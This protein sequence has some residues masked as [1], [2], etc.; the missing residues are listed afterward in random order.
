MWNFLTEGVR[1][2][3]KGDVP[4][5]LLFINTEG[6]LGNVMAGGSHEM[7]QIFDSLRRKFSRTLWPV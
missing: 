3:T 7:I 4:Q 6:L 5:E 1:D 2:P